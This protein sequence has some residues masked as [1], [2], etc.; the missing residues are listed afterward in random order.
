MSISFLAFA[1][2]KKQGVAH[3]DEYD[4]VKVEQMIGNDVS[5]HVFERTILCLN[6]RRETR[7]APTVTNQV[8]TL[9]TNITLMTITNQTVTLVTNQSRTLATNFVALPVPPPISATTTNEPATAETNQV[10]AI[11]ITQPPSSTNLSVTAASNVTVSKAGN[12]VVTTLNSQS[13]LSRQVTTTTNSLS[14]TTA[15]NQMISGETN[16]LVVT[17]TNQLITAVTNLSVTQPEQPLQDYYLY[18]ELTP[19]LDFVQQTGEPLVLLVDG[20]RHVLLQ[21]NSQTAFVARRGY[22][23]TI[24][25]ATQELLMDIAG[26]KQVKIRVR[27]VNAVIEKEMNRSSRNH[28]KAFVAK[29]VSRD[30]TAPVASISS[31]I[32]VAAYQA[33]P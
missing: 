30:P 4:A 16:Q 24:Y 12:Q 22:T 5:G 6:A 17:V 15:D 13:L 25:K 27:G 10:V 8:V 23:S 29:Y 28:F 33:Q 20:V 11:P 21:T 3:T 26:A 31:A 2:S 7:K 32:P 1:G 19:P 9:V 18:T 14:I